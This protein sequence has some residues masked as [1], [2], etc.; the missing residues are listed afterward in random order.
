[1]FKQLQMAIMKEEHTFV[2]GFCWQYKM[3]GSTQNLHNLLM[4]LGSI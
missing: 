1:M 4:K 3:V 2:T